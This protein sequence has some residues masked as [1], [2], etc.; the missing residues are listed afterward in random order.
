MPAFGPETR[1]G[2]LSGRGSYSRP[3]SSIYLPSNP[4]Q[5]WSYRNR[6]D[7][8]KQE[9]PS[10]VHFTFHKNHLALEK[11]LK[12]SIGSGFVKE[13]GGN[14]MRY[15]IADKQGVIRLTLLMNGYFRTP[16]SKLCIY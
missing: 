8:I 4:Y 7:Q 12:N 1:R 10:S 6:P 9:E 13:E 14:A 16:K 2:G 15:V 5:V 11:L 3:T